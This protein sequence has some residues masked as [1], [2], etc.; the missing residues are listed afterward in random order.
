MGSAAEQDIGSRYLQ[1]SRVEAIRVR[2]WGH[3]EAN[4]AVMII[5]RGARAPSDSE[6]SR[7][8]RALGVL[9]GDGGFSGFFSYWP[10]RR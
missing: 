2:H 9:A 5:L 3:I 8:A 1:K 6:A 10:Y 7:A 4:L